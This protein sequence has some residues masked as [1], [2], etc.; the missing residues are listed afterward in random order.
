M[1]PQTED[2]RNRKVEVLVAL[3]SLLSGVLLTLFSRVT[4]SHVI[5]NRP[6]RNSGVKNRNTGHTQY[7]LNLADRKNS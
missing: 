4:C 7:Y 2:E 3:R 1:L 5:L 6:K